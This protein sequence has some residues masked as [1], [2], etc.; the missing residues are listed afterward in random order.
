MSHKFIVTG[1]MNFA[2]CTTVRA[3][4]ESEAL[5]IA[6]ERKCNTDS[7]AGWRSLDSEPKLDMDMLT[8]KRVRE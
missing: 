1:I 7:K 8:V 2:V 5:S 3:Y 4:S 6:K